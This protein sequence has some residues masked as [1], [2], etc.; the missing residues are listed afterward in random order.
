MS[1]IAARFVGGPLD[2]EIRP[3]NRNATEHIICTLMPIDPGRPLD[4]NA[5]MLPFKH[6]Y[7]RGPDGRF[8]HV[9]SEPR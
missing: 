7:R 3:V 4:P 6:H 8:E 1:N 2:G 9:S 5:P